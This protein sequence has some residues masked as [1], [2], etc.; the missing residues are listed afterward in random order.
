MNNHLP[1][2]IILQSPPPGVDFGLQKGSGNTYEAIQIQRSGVDDLHFALTIQIK[3]DRQKDA[4][5]GFVGPFAQGS[6]PDKFIYLDIGTLAGQV[7]SC[8][9]RRLK[10]PFAGITWDMV[11]QVQNNS[12]LYLETK[13][14]GTA[15]DGGPNCATVKPFEGWKVRGL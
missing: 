1:L 13:V 14:A 5:P 3:G 9:T 12:Q 6:A 15:K 10:I 7:S 2:R 4:L 8:W 11:D